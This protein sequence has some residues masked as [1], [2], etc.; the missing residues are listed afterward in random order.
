MTHSLTRDLNILRVFLDFGKYPCPVLV[1]YSSHS[2]VGRMSTPATPSA[3]LVL[4]WFRDTNLSSRVGRILYFVM[5]TIYIKF[6]SYKRKTTA[7][8]FSRDSS[9]NI[10]SSEEESGDSRIQ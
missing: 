9:G 2:S 4:S 7:L 10:Y 3:S 1:G 5:C 6:R 8:S